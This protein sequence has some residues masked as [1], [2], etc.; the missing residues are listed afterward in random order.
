MFRIGLC[1]NDIS[2]IQS[3]KE[4]VAKYLAHKI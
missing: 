4:I 3:V 2:V 1:N